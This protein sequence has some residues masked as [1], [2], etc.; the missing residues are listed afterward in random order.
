M[1]LGMLLAMSLA[2]T[3]TVALCGGA[4]PSVA[5][6]AEAHHSH[7][8]SGSSSDAPFAGLDAGWMLLDDAGKAWVAVEL[9]SR[10]DL[11]FELEGL[12][13]RFPGMGGPTALIIIGAVLV[14][15]GAVLSIVGLVQT[16]VTSIFAWT[17][18]VGLGSLGLGVV[19]LIV[20]VASLA[21]STATR[22]RYNYRMKE[23]A[24]RLEVLDRQSTAPTGP[25]PSLLFA[26]F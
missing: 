13:A 2:L 19:L 6:L 11:A 1:A 8:S 14:L 9:L 22:T 17:L 4:V 10:A 24:N 3:L 23:L 25:S 5:S 18:G 12:R 26:R 16:L 20:G 15:T 7:H 21:S